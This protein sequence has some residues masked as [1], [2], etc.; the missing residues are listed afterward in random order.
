MR[1]FAFLL[2]VLLT[3]LP[4]RAEETVRIDMGAPEGTAVVRGAGLSLGP[5]VDEG[6]FT[7]FAGE[8]VEVRWT[9]GGVQV[10]GE[11]AARG[12]AVRIRAGR[13]GGLSAGGRTVRGE[14]VVRAAK[15]RLQL[16][17]VVPLEDYLGAVLGSEMPVSFPDEALKAQAVAARTY[18]LQKKLEAL[19]QP[20]HLGSSVLHQVYGGLQREEARTRAAV[21]ATRGE[22]LTHELAPIEAYF[23]ASCGGRTES[24]K[25]ALGR[26]L[27]YLQ[28]VSCRCGRTASAK[29]E[30]ELKPEELRAV[31]GGEVRRLEVE[32]RSTTGRVL[33]L[34]GA[35]R[36]VD[37]VTFRQK[38]GY[39]RVKSL[40]FEV[41][42]PRKKGQPFHLR[43]HG[44]GHGAG[45][46]QVGA[47]THAEDGWDYRRIL[48]HY[49]PGAE[50]QRLY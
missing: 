32:G 8:S 7:P 17:N 4:A 46:C 6:D 34:V 11:E 47:R 9:L 16:I 23:H 18:A 41:T 21:E 29:W 48:G 39:T 49:Y 43:G 26:G 27:S 37:A 20:F 24:G 28:S 38:L 33:A 13:E 15:G 31:F 10:A 5:D 19:G 12:E 25:A 14:V 42:A 45:M 1:S 40:W 2:S 44:Y 30:L 3:C 50:L 36:R 22:V 35:G